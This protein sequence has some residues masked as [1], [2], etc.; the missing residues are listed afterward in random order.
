MPDDLVDRWVE[1]LPGRVNVAI[2]LDHR[3]KSWNR[4]WDKLHEGKLPRRRQLATAQAG[5]GVLVPPL[6]DLTELNHGRNV[7]PDDPKAPY[8]EKWFPGTHGSV[9]GGGDIRGPA[10]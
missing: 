8:Q 2:E 9:G 3:L 5:N 7:P 1:G 10:S 4:L 6:G